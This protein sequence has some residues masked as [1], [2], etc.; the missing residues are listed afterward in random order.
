MSSE[1][2]RRGWRSAAGVVIGAVLALSFSALP[3]NAAN[4]A[5]VD[6]DAIGSITVHK[7][8]RPDTATNLPNNGTQVTV[9]A[10]VKPLAGVTFSVA[11][12]NTID[13]STNAG[14]AKAN[15]LSDGFNPRNVP[16]ELAAEGLSLGT[17]TSLTTDT[18]G[19]AS[20]AN[21]PVGL[22]LVSETQAPAGV[23]KSVPFLVSIPLTDPNNNNAW[24]YNVHVYPKNAITNAVKTVQDAAAT[25]LGD[26]VTWTIKSDIPDVD[27]IDAY[28]VTDK[29]DTR[30]TY[31]V[32]DAT[33]TT[34][35]LEDGTA[36]VAADY[37]IAFD[38]A[39]NTV[40]VTFTDAG[41]VKLAAHANTRVVTVIKTVV[42]TVGEIANEA[43]I[44][45]N[46]DSLNVK[47]GEPGG[48]TV[49]PP[50]VTK[51]GGLTLLKVNEKKEALAGAVFSIYGSA[52]DAQ[53]GTNPISLA[54]ATTFPVAADGTLT[55][56]GLRYSTWADGVQ[57]GP[58]DAGYREYFIV[59]VTAPT[60]YE[61]LAEPIK[62]TI[63]AAS[64]AVGVD[65]TVVNVP[66]NGGFTLPLTGGSGTV[67]LYGAGIVL[68]LGAVLLFV[69]S[70]RAQG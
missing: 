50:V 58:G 43:I 32:S 53:A 62:V 54:G 29:L 9:P 65:H 68:L 35:T 57:V 51:W 28:R 5:L 42:N 22:Y 60:G 40:S 4:T 30:L 12:V 52:A 64:T 26:P 27:I 8:E 23:T 38:A 14:W 49:T 69:R 6:G 70:R 55:L 46:A 56:S 13:L 7:Y 25:K 45:P 41:R 20:F 63:D 44:Y 31:N 67:L 10:T 47:P 34:V 16:A 3:A 61:L 48:P 11:Q 39:T 66:S 59:E 36:L 15:A 37:V 24:L 21:L 18:A 33:A 1:K 19:V 2:N 17:A